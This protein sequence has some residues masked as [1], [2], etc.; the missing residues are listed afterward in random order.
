MQTNAR[1]AVSVLV[2]A[3]VVAAA[4]SEPATA[5]AKGAIKFK[6]LDCVYVV[7]NLVIPLKG[8]GNR[9]GSGKIRCTATLAAAAGAENPETDVTMTLTGGENVTASQTVHA[10]LWTGFK[11][12][13]EIEV[14][15]PEEGAFECSNID[16]VVNLADG[17]TK[18]AKALADCPD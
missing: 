18:K 14:A 8:E 17:G 4:V 13:V 6:K 2:L 1:A 16:V 10:S 3:I 9:F 11:Y 15:F 5:H 7:N 12:A